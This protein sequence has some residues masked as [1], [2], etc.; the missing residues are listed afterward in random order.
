MKRC[1]TNQNLHRIRYRQDQRLQADDLKDDM[2]Y[3]AQLRALHIRTVHR[4]WGVALGFEVSLDEA[5]NTVTVTPGL[6]YDCHGH[7]ILSSRSQIFSAPSLPNSVTAGWFELVIRYRQL[8]TP[9]LHYESL[10]SSSD[11]PTL[12]Q[13]DWRWVYAGPVDD[14]AAHPPPLAADVRLGK[15]IPLAR[16]QVTSG[17]FVALDFSQR[18]NAQK[19]VRP[20]IATGQQRQGSLTINGSILSWSVEIDT[21]SAGFSSETPLY[22][23]SLADHP[24]SPT[25][26]FIQL[27]QNSG[28]PRR[29]ELLQR[30]IGPW[31][32]INHP[33]R[34]LFRLEVRMA[35][36]DLSLRN[37]LLALPRNILQLP[38]T[39]NWLG[40]E[41]VGSCAPV[42][43]SNNDPFL[44]Y[45]YSYFIFV[46]FFRLN[47][48]FLN[49]FL[50]VVPN[51]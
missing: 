34:N 33:N 7:E 50:T 35:V 28:G 30:A 23:V 9:S 16:V 40:I 14:S 41:P 17:Q 19:L 20:H 47:L 25:S 12:E 1:T 13:P 10:C 4:T 8:S 3:E 36:A 27:L 2:A 11:S 44:L 24:L 43:T 46:P 31:V 6:A 51:L 37:Q 48:S 21:S 29:E 22:F 42:I 45:L 26:G 32:S 5:D 49:A 18:R 15:E 39:V 38:I